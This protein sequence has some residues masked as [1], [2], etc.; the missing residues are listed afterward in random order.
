MRFIPVFVGFFIGYNLD[1]FAKVQGSSMLP[2]LAPN[3]HIFFIPYSFLHP[4][5][6]CK[7]FLHFK[8]EDKPLVNEGDVV[9]VKISETLCVCKRIKKVF[10]TTAAV[11]EWETSQF[12]T[13]EDHYRYYEEKKEKDD[14]GPLQAEGAPLSPAETSAQLKPIRLN[15]WD[16]ARLRI[17]QPSWWLWLEGDNPSQSMDSRQ[18]GAIPQ[19]CL[20]GKVIASIYP[21]PRIIR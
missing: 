5:Y 20:R 10:N 9:T 17:P 7:S 6:K 12:S 19:E 4:W 11:N 14:E 1:F 3:D 13:Y 15:T 21:A 8:R 16:Q 18:C 2:T